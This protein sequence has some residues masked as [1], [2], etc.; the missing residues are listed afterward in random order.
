M[1]VGRFDSMQAYFVH[2]RAESQ[3]GGHPPCFNR[4]KPEDTHLVFQHQRRSKPES[5]NRQPP[6]AVGPF[7]PVAPLPMHGSLAQAPEL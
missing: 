3:T 4:R 2:D 7:I 5:Q 6:S 1:R